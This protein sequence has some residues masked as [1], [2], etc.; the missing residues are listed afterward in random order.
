YLRITCAP[1]R[2]CFFSRYAH[3]VFFL[4]CQVFLLL[5][6]FLLG[7]FLFFARSTYSGC[8][9][10]NLFLF[11]S[12]FLFRAFYL[13]HTHPPLAGCFYFPITGVFLLHISAPG[14][15]IILQLSSSGERQGTQ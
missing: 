4:C 2:G 14:V 8:F 7:V 13:L 15:F 1:Y 6:L 10:V 5:R 3:R 11:P 12:V 9:F